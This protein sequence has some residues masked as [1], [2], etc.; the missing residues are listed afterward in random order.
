MDKVA[1]A[2]SGRSSC[3][4][5][6]NAG[7]TSLKLGLFVAGR[8]RWRRVFPNDALDRLGAQVPDLLAG[9]PEPEALLL[10]SVRPATRP[11]LEALAG[12]LSL[13][14]RVV[15]RAALGVE[16][17]T[18]EPERVG[19]DRLLNARAAIARGA[20]EWVVL[21]C[22]TAITCDRVTADGRFLGGA[23]APGADLAARALDQGTALLPYVGLREVDAV[24]GHDTE[25]ALAAGLYWGF[26]GLVGKLVDR[27]REEAGQ[28][29]RVLITGGD[30][31]LLMAE[32]GDA[33]YVEDLTLEGIAVHHAHDL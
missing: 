9:G 31:A 25:S 33:Q 10:G 26:R 18:R 3:I 11:A 21:D 14:L 28:P 22:G 27:A 4:L 2:D 15:D 6:A 32:L 29:L 5:A 8:A 19:L 16:N 1:R 24:V 20:A 7:N 13:S 23:I 30:G 17:L 12:Q